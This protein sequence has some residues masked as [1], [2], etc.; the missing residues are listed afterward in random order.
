MF[1]A[2]DL[3]LGLGF[4]RHSM[5]VSRWWALS[6]R[7]KVGNHSTCRGNSQWWSS[8]D[9]IRIFERGEKKE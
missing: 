3:L 4:L 7:V 5:K 9:V 6:A 8:E 2:S 1:S